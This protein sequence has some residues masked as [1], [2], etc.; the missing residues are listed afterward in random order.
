MDIFGSPI[1]EIE[2]GRGL[3]IVRVGSGHLG[4]LVIVFRV[5]LITILAVRIPSRRFVD[6]RFD[7]LKR[8]FFPSNV[9]V[10]FKVKEMIVVRAG[11]VFL[12]SSRELTCFGRPVTGQDV[13]CRHYFNFDDAVLVKNVIEDIIV[14][15]WSNDGPKDQSSTWNSA[16]KVITISSE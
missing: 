6:L 12:Y 11:H 8:V 16:I 4:L 13:P 5:L 9:E 10:Y 2:V 14:V 1:V 3:E 15:V 7:Q